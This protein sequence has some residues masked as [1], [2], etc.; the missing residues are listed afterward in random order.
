MVALSVSTSH[1][2]SPAATSSPAATFH[3]EIPPACIVGE[4]L[5][6]SSTSCAGQARPGVAGARGAAAAA[7]AGAAVAAGAAEA[8]APA[9]GAS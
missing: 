9:A 3:C 7:A 4:R 5:G 1:S 6:I 2:T 8:S